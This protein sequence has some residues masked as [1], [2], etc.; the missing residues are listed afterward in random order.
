MDANDFTILEATHLVRG[1]VEPRSTS[2]SLGAGGVLAN[3]E[4]KYAVDG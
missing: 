3:V 4:P 2:W 1:G